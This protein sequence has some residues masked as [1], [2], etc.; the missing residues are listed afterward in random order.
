VTWRSCLLVAALA[1]STPADD[2]PRLEPEHLPRELHGIVPGVTT[3]AELA[4][5]LPDA[6][7]TRDLRYGGR[8]EVVLSS[9]P[10]IQVQSQQVGLEAWLIRIT[11]EVR[12]TSL[13]VRIDRRCSAIARDFG[14]QLRP[15]ACN[16][17]GEPS[18]PN[19]HDYCTHTPDG[20]YGIDVSCFD[21]PAWDAVGH[22]S[23][24]VEVIPARAR[25][26]RIST[27]SSPPATA[28]P[29]PR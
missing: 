10:A 18:R 29:G 25:E 14:A 19:Q 16:E 7:A 26:Y 13:F 20:R 28:G 17:S 5:L 23:A 15:G 3:E 22:L 9:E 4:A 6:T 11:G 24:W 21:P 2:R 27:P 8:V 12:V 1:C